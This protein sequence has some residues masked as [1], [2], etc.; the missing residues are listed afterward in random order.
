M[1]VCGTKNGAQ[2]QNTNSRDFTLT[3]LDGEEYTLSALKGNVVFI[4]FWTT[5][6]PPCRNS[7]PVL[8]SLYDKYH[9]QGFIVL[10]IS[11]ESASVLE[12]FRDEY[13]MNY[14]VLVDD[15]NV[16]QTY[17]VQSI[18]NMFIFNKEG[19]LAKHQ[20]GFSPEMEAGF[21]AFIDSLLRE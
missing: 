8:I 9:D 4:D 11:N 17:G 7:I 21:D 6:C 16:M 19:E 2:T 20:V 14:P 12:Q 10:G 13:Q 3:S 15:K 1:C 5:W 18:P